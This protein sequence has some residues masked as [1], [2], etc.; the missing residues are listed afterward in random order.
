M[1]TM[2]GAAGAAASHD[3]GAE[4]KVA[5]DKLGVGAEPSIAADMSGGGAKPTVGATSHRSGAE[6]AATAEPG[7]GD[8]PCTSE[9]AARVDSAS[10]RR[11]PVR[12]LPMT[13][14]RGGLRWGLVTVLIVTSV[15]KFASLDRF[16][17]ALSAMG[18]FDPSV[19]PVLTWG[20]PVLEAV[21]ALLLAMPRVE[22]LGL[23]LSVV[24]FGC[25]CGFHAYLHWKGIVVPCGCAGIRETDVGRADHLAMSAGCGVMALAAVFLLC[26]PE[27]RSGV[28]AASSHD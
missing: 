1:S 2:T 26:A 28:R 25:F 3:G 8:E 20:V 21:T 5:A 19:V 16:A 14:L 6:P 12:R 15:W 27:P 13:A 17:A 24:Q 23:G 22:V 11:S 9:A 10:G 7:C 18:F 4:P